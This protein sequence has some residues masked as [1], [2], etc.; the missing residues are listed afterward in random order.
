MTFLTRPRLG[1]SHLNEHRFRLNP[2]CSC[3]LEIE[4]TSHYVLHCHHFSNNRVVLMNRVKPICVN[5]DSI[6]D[7]VKEDL[8]LCGDSQFDQNK[9]KVILKATIN[10]ILKDSLDHFLINVPLLIN[11]QLFTYNSNHLVIKIS[12]VNYC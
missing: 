7:N 5:F 4:D 9:N 1:L 2:V 8:L 10:Y 3:S 12:R 11:V 6:S